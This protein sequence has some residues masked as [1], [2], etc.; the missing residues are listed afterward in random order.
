MFYLVIFLY[1]RIDSDT[2][3]QLGRSIQ[4]FSNNFSFMQNSSIRRSRL[5][6]KVVVVIRTLCHLAGSPLVKRHLADTLVT[7]VD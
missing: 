5:E 7:S 3:W 4:F 6:K 2:I 1:K